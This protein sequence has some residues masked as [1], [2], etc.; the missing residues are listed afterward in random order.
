[1][2]IY[3]F[4]IKGL[5]VQTGWVQS[6][7]E[8]FIAFLAKDVGGFFVRTDILKVRTYKSECHLIK[9]TNIQ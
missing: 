1:M 4:S 6:V 9:L 3:T 7:T 8:K 5:F 2:C